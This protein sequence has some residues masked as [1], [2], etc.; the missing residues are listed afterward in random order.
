MTEL[1]RLQG[2]LGYVFADEALLSRA[3]SHASWAHEHGTESNERLEFLGDAVLQLLTTHRLYEGF[4]DADEGTL[5]RVRTRIVRR[6][7]LAQWGQQLGLDK[8]LRLGAGEE[9]DG[10]RTR[11][12]LLCDAME[13][14]V[15]AAYLDGGLEASRTVLSPLMEPLISEA[16]RDVEAFGKSPVSAIQEFTQGRFGAAPEYVGRT[17]SGPAH[18]RVF[19]V[20]ARLGGRLIG[21]GEGPTKAAARARAA[22]TGLMTLRSET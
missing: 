3:L 21:V 16:A 1:E 19:T 12:K 10:G 7:T 20:E 22:E 17:P 6:E 11:S 9:S 5:S 15:G 18:A 4:V 13:A 8:A 14:V 2:A